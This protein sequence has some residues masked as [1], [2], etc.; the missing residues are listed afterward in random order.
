VEVLEIEGDTNMS[1]ATRIETG[2]MP[3]RINDAI[4]SASQR[5]GV[6]FGYLYNQAKIESGLKSNAQAKTSSAA[7]LYQFTKQTW[8][9]TVKTHGA[10]HGLAW[11]AN[12]ITENR[13][14]YEVADPK[15]RKQILDLRNLPEPASV[16]AAEFASDNCAFLETQLG[17]RPEPVDLYLAHFLGAA[18]AA[19]FLS[20]HA[21]NPD[22]AAA[23]LFPAAAQANRSVFYALDGSARSLG[24][25]RSL[26]AA[27]LGGDTPMINE[28]TLPYAA[29]A[30]VGE[31]FPSINNTPTI[32][33]PKVVA[34]VPPLRMLAIEPM[35]ER[36]SI[37]FARR[38]YQR[39]AALDGD[40]VS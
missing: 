12:A 9:A 23:P 24:Q 10:E 8:L 31:G 21:A 7:G 29:G 15:L 3:S 38:A 39:L 2:P 40:R 22:A 17:R 26:F 28:D 20:A 27:K 6:G 13:G 34:E 30:L 4:R 25:I 32:H 1:Q 35:P 5:T 36:L 18:G 16:M 14:K 37:D 11:A 19:S 33:G